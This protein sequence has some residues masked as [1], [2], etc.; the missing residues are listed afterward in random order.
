MCMA[1]YSYVR[2][3]YVVP[4]KVRE[5][6]G[7]H[8]TELADSCESHCECWESSPVPLREHPVLLTA[9]LCLQLQKVNDRVPNVLPIFI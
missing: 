8:G 1:V 5:G 6:M 2:H 9:E 7:Y 3:A 4:A